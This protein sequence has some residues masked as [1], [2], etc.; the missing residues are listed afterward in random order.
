VNFNQQSEWLC[1]N[2]IKGNI[3]KNN[4]QTNFL[5]AHSLCRG[6]FR[7]VECY[8]SDATD[9]HIAYTQARESTLNEVLLEHIKKGSLFSTKYTT[10]REN[11]IVAPTHEILQ[12]AREVGFNAYDVALEL[13]RI[14]TTIDIDFIQPDILEEISTL[15]DLLKGE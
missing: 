8:L 1:F 7:K 13:N 10:T 9:E 6:N 3:M 14:Y 2:F 15:L 4:L 11:V 5:V 12:I